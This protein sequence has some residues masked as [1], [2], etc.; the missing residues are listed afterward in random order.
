MKIDTREKRQ[1][2]P[3]A[4]TLLKTNTDAVRC[5]SPERVMHYM[6]GICSSTLALTRRKR[7]PATGSKRWRDRCATS[8]RSDGS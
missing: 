4:A 6:S 8:S 7:R 2:L 3:D 1:A 5:N